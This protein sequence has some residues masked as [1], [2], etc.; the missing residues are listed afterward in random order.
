LINPL[1]KLRHTLVVILLKYERPK[2]KLDTALK[3]KLVSSG[4]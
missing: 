1:I 4:H 2:V 3:T